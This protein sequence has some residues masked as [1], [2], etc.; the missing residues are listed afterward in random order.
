M[1]NYPELPAFKD[2]KDYVLMYYL[3]PIDVW[4]NQEFFDINLLHVNIMIEIERRLRNIFKDKYD[5]FIQLMTDYNIV[6][7]GS[8]IMQC[9]LGEDWSSDLDLFYDQDPTIN[10]YGEPYEVS[11]QKMLDQMGKLGIEKFLNEGEM[12][13]YS[14][15]FKI[16]NLINY[17]VNQY[18]VQLVCIHP[19]E[20]Y[21]IDNLSHYYD[22]DHVLSHTYK[23]IEYPKDEFIGRIN[24]YLITEFDFDVCTNFYYVEKGISKLKLNNVAGIFEKKICLLTTGINKYIIRSRLNKYKDRGFTFDVEIK[25]HSKYDT[26]KYFIC[27]EEMSEYSYDVGTGIYNLD[28][29]HNERKLDDHKLSRIYIPNISD[30]NPHLKVVLYQDNK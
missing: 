1:N 19:T 10:F 24:K 17:N 29:R 27:N 13:H 21:V 30:R 16:K 7:S 14:N 4:N 3:R 6:I 22:E 26:N 12:Y 8:F 20:L 25:P 28:Y 15:N 2:V 18:K 11:H 5:Q 23:L 9:M